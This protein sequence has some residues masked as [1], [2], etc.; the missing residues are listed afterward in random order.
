MI[1][2]Q[3]P[4]NFFKVKSINSRES[5]ELDGSQMSAFSDDSDLDMPKMNSMAQTKTSHVNNDINTITFQKFEDVGKSFD[6]TRNNGAVNNFQTDP[7]MIGG[8]INVSRQSLMGSEGKAVTINDSMEPPKGNLAQAV[9]HTIGGNILQNEATM[10]EKDQHRKHSIIVMRN[11]EKYRKVE[12][13]VYYNGTA[14]TMEEEERVDS[15]EASSVITSEDE[16][17]VDD[18]VVM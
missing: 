4:D 8:S 3:L 15:D 6:N 16:F 12:K 9:K 13:K 11:G 1:H 5:R 7:V 18:E 2:K 10:R 17:Q 14:F